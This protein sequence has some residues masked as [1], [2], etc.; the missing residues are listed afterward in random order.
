MAPIA[1]V[2]AGVPTPPS[3]AQKIATPTPATPEQPFMVAP[4]GS[5]A[6]FLRSANRN[7][8]VE[9]MPGGMAV[10][11]ANLNVGEASVVAGPK[12]FQAQREKPTDMGSQQGLDNLATAT[13]AMAGLDRTPNFTNEQVQAQSAG[14]NRL[15]RGFMSPR[16]RADTLTGERRAADRAFMGDKLTAAKDIETTKAGAATDE[17][18]T[19]ADA[20]KYKVDKM[21]EMGA[22]NETAKPGRF[23]EMYTGGV[24]D[25]ATGALNKPAVN[26]D[27]Y[28][29]AY[30]SK[31]GVGMLTRFPNVSNG[32]QAVLD[33]EWSKTGLPSERA[34]H[35]GGRGLDFDTPEEV[36]SLLLP[37][38]T[39][40]TIRG[41]PAIVE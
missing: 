26:L 3:V 8:P 33:Q 36:D 1:G 4:E 30:D 6:T 29:S 41:R 10:P 22:F 40:I 7:T 11:A 17:A 5:A 9:A 28:N 24:L 21:A 25:T 2:A 27:A 31:K 20:E 19:Q 16:E 39:R 15:K 34:P 37:R 12:F 35:R 13:N 38:G 32:N 18:K 14:V 23:K